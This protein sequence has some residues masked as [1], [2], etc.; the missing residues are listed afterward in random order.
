L[1]VLIQNLAKVRASFAVF[2]ET[3][4]GKGGLCKDATVGRFFLVAY[5][6]PLKAPKES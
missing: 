6:N 2:L 1:A 3:N 5:L 4:F